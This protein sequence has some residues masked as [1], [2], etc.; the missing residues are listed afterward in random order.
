MYI[1]LYS[2]DIKPNQEDNFLK[3]WKAL[4]KL[5]VK[6]EGG[7]GSRLHLEKPL[8]YIAYAQWPDKETFTNA[9]NKLPKEADKFRNIMRE[10]CEKFEILNKLKVVED[11]LLK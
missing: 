8:K 9:G 5:I 11:L 1:V 3:A 2:F 6:H 7:L 10:S 4:T